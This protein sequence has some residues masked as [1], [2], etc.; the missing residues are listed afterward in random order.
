VAGFCENGNEPFG[1]TKDEN[2][3]GPLSKYQ[4]LKMELVDGKGLP[5]AK[6]HVIKAYSGSGGKAL[7][8]LDLSNGDECLDSQFGRL[9]QRSG[10][11]CTPVSI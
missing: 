5:V 9:I 10:G 7:P 6:H 8:Y 1:S 4:F 11:G 2:F 3:R